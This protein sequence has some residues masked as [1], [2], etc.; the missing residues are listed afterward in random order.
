MD[1]AWH[2]L[3][4]PCGER[5]HQCT[6]AG[7]FLLFLVGLSL[8]L[9]VDFF[10]LFF[11]YQLFEIAQGLAY[12]HSQDI[13]HGD[14]RGTNI[15]VDDKGH[16]CLADFGLAVF[17]NATLAN[18]SSQH[19]GSVRWMGPELLY[20]QSCGLENFQRTFANDVYSF[21]C[22]CIEVCPSRDKVEL[23]I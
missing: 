13:I 7:V 12:L 1:A 21:A 5:Q 18:Q 10:F 6:V 22:V 11:S 8:P 20:P 9:G 17:S 14:L 19:G 4:T 3:E 23:R 15:L 2:N 16:A